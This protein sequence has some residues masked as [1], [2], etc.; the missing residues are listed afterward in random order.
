MTNSKKV[1]WF[2]VLGIIVGTV[3]GKLLMTLILKG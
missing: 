1:N 3:A 2:L